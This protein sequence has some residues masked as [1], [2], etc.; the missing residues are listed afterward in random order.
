LTS[1][2][3]E[4]ENFSTGIL[5]RLYPLDSVMQQIFDCLRVNLA[6]PHLSFKLPTEA[7]S[8]FP[9]R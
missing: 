6:A 2:Q 5:W 8:D 1:N 3:R 9:S 7:S 4:P